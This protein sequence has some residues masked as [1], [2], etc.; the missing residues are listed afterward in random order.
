MHAARTQQT[1]L[2]INPAGQ[3]SNWTNSDA[4]N[5]GTGTPTKNVAGADNDQPCCEYQH[6]VTIDGKIEQAYVRACH[7]ADGIWHKL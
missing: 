1:A 7:Q 6:S 5:S 4:G 2:E 3:S